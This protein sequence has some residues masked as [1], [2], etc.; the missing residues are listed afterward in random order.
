VALAQGG[1]GTRHPT[2]PAAAV[3]PALANVVFHA[4]GCRLRDLPIGIENLL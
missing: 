3:S 4:T 2:S 1:A